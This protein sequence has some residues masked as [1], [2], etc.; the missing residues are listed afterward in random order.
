MKPPFSKP[1][2]IVLKR[3]IRK[4]TILGGQ[5]DCFGE[6][7]H[8]L[9]DIATTM[10]SNTMEIHGY[11]CM[12]VSPIICAPKVLEGKNVVPICYRIHCLVNK[13][14]LHKN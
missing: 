3:G 9:I 4:L 2:A 8:I 1:R 14:M 13:S 12:D 6:M 5:S 7:W 10:E 11:I